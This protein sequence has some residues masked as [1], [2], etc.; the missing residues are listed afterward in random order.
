M[1]L[2]LKHVLPYVP[3]K[4][5]CQYV[6]IVDVQKYKNATFNDPFD[7]EDTGYGL[8]VAEIKEIKLYKNYWKAYI[9]KYHGHLK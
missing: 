7:N 2:E 9:G 3:Y 5:K 4:I 8:K 6:G 1:N